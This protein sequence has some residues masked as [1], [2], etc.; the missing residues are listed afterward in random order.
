MG[1]LTDRIAE[2]QGMKEV[3]RGDMFSQFIDA[4]PNTPPGVLIY[5][6]ARGKVTTATPFAG[7]A[8]G[9]AARELNRVGST[10]RVLTTNFEPGAIQGIN[11]GD[12]VKFV[13]QNN[14]S[15]EGIVMQVDGRVDKNN[16]PYVFVRRADAGA[17][18][19]RVIQMQTT[20]KDT[21]R[22]HYYE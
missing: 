7:V 9:T 4:N 13:D 3:N 18:P 21:K 5:D 12:V 1:L 22:T 17:R 19:T 2:A 14:P 8:L 20:N 11:P 10:G 16:M 15:A 6:K